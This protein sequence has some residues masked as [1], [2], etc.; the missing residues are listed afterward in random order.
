MKSSTL[1]LPAATLAL[2][3]TACGGN[4]TTGTTADKDSPSTG[5]QASGGVSKAD[6]C[7]EFLKYRPD[8]S[9]GAEAAYRAGA[10]KAGDLA[11]ETEDADL[12]AALEALA[13]NGVAQAEVLASGKQPTTDELKVSSDLNGKVMEL[14][15][16]P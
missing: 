10:K 2:V 5:S 13:E 15:T 12:K 3:L 4:D 6:T 11:A 16:G 7:Q 8:T 14:C 9:G 1:L